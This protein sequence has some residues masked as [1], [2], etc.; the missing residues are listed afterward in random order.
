M[1]KRLSRRRFLKLVGAS[2]A[3]AG[4][5]ALQF[6]DGIHDLASNLL[7][8]RI[9]FLTSEEDLG[10]G[11]AG[12]SLKVPSMARIRPGELPVYEGQ[13][14]ER[15]AIT[16]YFP[17]LDYSRENTAK[18]QIVN[19]YQEDFPLLAKNI[20]DTATLHDSLYPMK[21][22]PDRFII[23]WAP[24]FPKFTPVFHLKHGW[25][26]A[27]NGTEIYIKD[28]GSPE[29]ALFGN[30]ARKYELSFPFCLQSK[31]KKIVTFGSLGSNHC[32]YTSLTAACT[33]LGKRFG[34]EEPEVFVNL[35]R[36]R[37]NPAVLNKLRYLLAL[38]TRIRF[39]DDDFEVGVNILANRLREHYSPVDD[40]GYC[41]P[42]GSNPLTTLAH[43]NA[44]FELNEQIEQGTV[45]LKEPPDYIFTP[46]GSGG[47]SM[48]LA[49][50]C[51]LLGWNTIV[52]GTTSQDKSIW[53]RAVVN[54]RPGQPF[55]VENAAGLLEK[56]IALLRSFD[57]QGAVWNRIDA[58]SILTKNFLYD[59]VTWKPAYGVPSKKTKAVISAMR[60][61]NGVELDSTFSGKSFTTLV[62]YA[63]K[64]LLRGKSVL[65][66]NTNHR[67]DYTA[68]EKVR[69]ADLNLLPG[70]LTAYLSRN[71]NLK[72]DRDSMQG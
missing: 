43:V 36:E 15:L 6:R 5:G 19:I 10:T 47:T 67:Y 70:N 65:F 50:G 72:L 49:L 14:S 41:E 27:A 17:Q 63:E 55:L 48:G 20:A 40:L 30:K 66:W 44:I 23:P 34:R 38:G 13:G 35:Y 4:L 11:K 25:S 53:E 56:T 33:R 71:W 31:A 18:V 68:N 7:E 60:V 16:R 64:G 59:N 69:D 26:V 46:L 2:A 12:F 22:S 28:E 1:S 52:V 29:Y 21:A 39:L 42:G 57:L 51:Y 54:G 58:E 45:P 61:R 37:Y 32:V 3:V 8:N 62:D 9:D 24:L